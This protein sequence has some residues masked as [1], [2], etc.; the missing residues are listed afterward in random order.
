[1]NRHR[2]PFY[3]ALAISLCLHVPLLW[4]K[5][6]FF[7]KT[8]NKQTLTVELTLQKPVYRKE[9]VESPI[10]KKDTNTNII[11]ADK[12][13]NNQERISF[14]E[15]AYLKK[16]LEID[17]VIAS[18]YK[19]VKLKIWI[20]AFGKAEQAEVLDENMD[21]NSKNLIIQSVLQ[22]EFEAAKYKNQSVKSVISG[23]IYLLD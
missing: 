1:M 7:E 21:E 12:S 11:D 3:I 17:P 15:S 18:I 19:S 20:D 2:Q 16:P 22:A 5:E 4:Q 13:N 14:D 6:D 9:N 8:T 10:H 23:E